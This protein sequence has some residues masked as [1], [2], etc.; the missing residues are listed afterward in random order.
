MVEMTENV[1]RIHEEPTEFS[2]TGI[3]DNVVNWWDAM[4]LYLRL[5]SVLLS[6]DKIEMLQ[7]DK[8]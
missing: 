3:W 8:F 1:G 5:E 4:L 6:H 7:T 2:N